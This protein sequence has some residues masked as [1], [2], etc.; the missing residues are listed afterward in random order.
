MNRLMN[1]LADK[2]K[3]MKKNMKKIS[4]LSKGIQ[5]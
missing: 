5:N 2:Y 3:K 4:I 1:S